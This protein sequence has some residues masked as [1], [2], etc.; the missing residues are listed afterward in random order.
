MPEA[1]GRSIGDVLLEQGVVTQAQLEE[2][3]SNQ[4]VE[5]GGLD[6]ALLRTG[7]VTQTEITRAWAR[8][9]GREVIDLATV[10]ISPAL[11]E[12]IPQAIAKRQNILPVSR[13]GGRIIVASAEPLDFNT[14]DNLRFLL[15]SDIDYVLADRESLQEAVSRSYGSVE[16]SV[17]TLLSEFTDSD[18]SRVETGSLLAKGQQEES[19]DAPIVRLVH[20]IITDAI[21]QRASDIHIEPLESRLR[22]RYRIDGVCHEMQSPPKRLQGAIIS[23]VKIMS[24]MD[25]AEKRLPQDG[26]IQM[27][28][29]GRDVDFRV[30]ALPASHGESMV[31]RILDRESVLINIEQLG[32]DPEDHERFQRIIRRPNGIFLVTGPTGSGKTTTLYAALNEL[33]RPD[34]KIITAEDPVEYTLSGINQV[35]VSAR[36]GLTFSRILR[37]VLRQA[38][39]VI[40]VGEIRDRETAEI[41]IQAALTGHLVFSTLHTNDAPSALTRLIDIG[42][43]PFLCASAVMAVM[44][45]RLVRVICSECKQ[46]YDPGVAKLKAAGLTDE[47]IEKTKF[48][49]GTG[50]R[51]CSN[52]AYRGR[53][54]IFELMRMNP[55]LR[56]LAFNCAPRSEIA[57]AAEQSGMVTLRRDGIRKV[58]AGT[59]TVDEVLRITARGEDDI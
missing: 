22:V 59:T 29:S 30:S 46:P 35:E 47:Q 8:Y 19:D 7:I 58:L 5:G 33:N 54:A 23:R 56:E 45:Q 43:K 40:L 21:S 16:E 4:Q 37:S 55:T 26:R 13:E 20:M 39:N 15:G 10:Q 2:A 14:L 41:A 12:L 50:C 11:L 53:T 38:P 42:V 6:D 24:G 48:E 28:V 9:Y 32:F 34:T 17:D 52:T 36:I 57:K 25:I 18:I 3:Q 31:L 51:N 1:V 27:R 49:H 44:A